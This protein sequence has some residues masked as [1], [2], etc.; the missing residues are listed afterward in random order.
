MRLQ[1]VADNFRVSRTDLKKGAK[2]KTTLSKY[3]TSQE[4]FES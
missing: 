3:T 1:L 2:E 4:I